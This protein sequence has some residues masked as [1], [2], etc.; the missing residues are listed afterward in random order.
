MSSIVDRY[1]HH[2]ISEFIIFDI[3]LYNQQTNVGKNVRKGNHK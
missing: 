1:R 3:V 2:L